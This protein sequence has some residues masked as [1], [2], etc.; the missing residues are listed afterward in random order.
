MAG[1]AARAP[2]QRKGWAVYARSTTI[3]ARPEDIDAGIRFVTEEVM[4]LAMTLEG[5]VGMSM[6]VDRSTGRCIST[7]A[8]LDEATMHASENAVKPLRTRGAE[9]LG[10]TPQVDEW[11]IALMHRDHLTSAS[12]CAR[13]TW[14]RV[15]PESADATIEMF[16]SL[17]LPAIE[18]MPGFCSASLMANR[19]TGR[20]VSSVT[21]DS[22]E[23][24]ESSRELASSLRGR[25]AGDKAG[26]VEDVAE[27]ELALAHLR[28]PELV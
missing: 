25:I 20:A 21:W 24:M 27:F 18:A 1:G 2:P 14:L 12:T 26:Q 7:S 13:C 28:V 15:P 4:P 6:L 9:L 8:W 3:H 23:A 11:E 5:C 22:R 16:R 10:G 17:V 19:A